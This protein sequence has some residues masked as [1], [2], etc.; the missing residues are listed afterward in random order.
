MSPEIFMV[1]PFSIL[2]AKRFNRDV[3]PAPEAPNIAV[4][5]PGLQI[6]VVS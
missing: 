6:P 1:G 3:L 2:L 5:Y 4:T